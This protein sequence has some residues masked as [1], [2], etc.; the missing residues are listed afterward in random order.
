MTIWDRKEQ[1][2]HFIGNNFHKV[3][4][5]LSSESSTIYELGTINTMVGLYENDLKAEKTEAE[6][7]AIWHLM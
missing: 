5:C 2:A 1:T 7:D 4:L 6:K 3:C